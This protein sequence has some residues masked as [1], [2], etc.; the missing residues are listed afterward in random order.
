MASLDI[1]L[2]FYGPIDLLTA[3]VRSVLA[4]DDPDWVLTVVDDAHPDPDV[5]TWFT[6]LDDPRVRY[7]RNEVNLGSNRNFQRCLDLVERDL[8][9]ILGGDDLLLPSYVR[10]V[11]SAHAEHPDA[12]V[13]QP[14]VVVID[15]D[16]RPART[17]V[18]QAKRRLYAPRDGVQRMTGEALA[19]SLL[20]GN[21]LYFPS[22][23]WQ[24]AAVRQVG[25]RTG[26]DTTQD[27]GLVLDLVLGGATLLVV[28]TV[29]FEYRRHAA[30][31]S[32]WRATTGNR[33]EEER[34]FYDEAAEQMSAKGWHRAAATARRHL[35][36]RLHAATVLPRAVV[37]RQPAAVRSL[38]RH[39]LGRQPRP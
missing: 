1:M 5:A 21:W 22:L 37:Q 38:A 20:R 6:R 28:P 31:E 11:R 29:C 2:P 35:S 34:R 12:T 26:L 36:S 30:S 7:L 39:V 27:L 18:D 4:Q 33:F 17:L 9:T 16:G 15:Q 10:T 32:S 23:C 24:S 3:T 8:V 19:V 14:G 13:V 25:F